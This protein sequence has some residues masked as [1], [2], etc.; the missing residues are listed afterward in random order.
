MRGEQRRRWERG[1]VKAA[2][3]FPPCRG[4]A[5]RQRGG[6]YALAGPIKSLLFI[7][8]N[9]LNSLRVFFFF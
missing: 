5:V 7:T 6:S 4:T 9:E 1:E 2:L 3:F 8:F